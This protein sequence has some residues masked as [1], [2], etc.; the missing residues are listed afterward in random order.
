MQNEMI[1]AVVSLPN[2]HTLYHSGVFFGNQELVIACGYRNDGKFGY[3]IVCE[4]RDEK[5]VNYGNQYAFIQKTHD[6]S[7]Q[8]ALTKLK[9]IVQK[10]NR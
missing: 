4:Q 10:E 2:D 8:E 6:K 1:S 3:F 9:E 7:Y 5:S